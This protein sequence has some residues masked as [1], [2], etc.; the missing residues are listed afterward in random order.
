MAFQVTKSLYDTLVEV[1]DRGE[2]KPA[3]A[4]S[5]KVSPDGLSWTFRLRPGVRFHHGKLLDATDVKAT[6]ERILNPSTYSPKRSSFEAIRRVEVL[7]PQT[8]RITLAERYAPFLATLAEGWAAILPADLIARKHD[9]ATRPVGTGPFMLAEWQRDAFLRLR[10]FEGYWVPGQPRLQEVVIR[11]VPE[12]TIKV[13]GLLTGEFDAVDAVPFRDLAR[14]RASPHVRILQQ[15]TSLINVVAMNHARK[16]LGDV[17]VRRALWHAIDRVQVLRTAYGPESVPSAVF[18][19]VAS[20][21]YVDLGDPYP[22]DSDR[23]RRLLREAGYGGGLEL[24]LVLPQPYPAH[25][26][27]GQLIQAMLHR[28]GV[29]ARIRVV[30]WGY[31]L[32]RVYG[33]GDF[34]LTVIGHTGKLDPDGRLAGFGQADRNYVRYE[35]P[36]VAR[37]LATGRVQVNPAVRRQVYREALRRMTEDAVMVFLGTPVRYVGL[38]ANVRGFRQLYAIDT[39]DFRQITK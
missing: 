37:L 6:L 16:P 18:M 17:R 9:F 20:P 32:S 38:R 30:E 36:V 3:L 39:Y 4:E 13:A 12:P 19:D 28:V 33:G 7:G 2:L 22:F 26:E 25:I 8:V 1:D 23:A 5:W 29:Q 34:D 35:N 14:V 27:A 24:D 31:W 10:R 11:I 21:Y 15:L